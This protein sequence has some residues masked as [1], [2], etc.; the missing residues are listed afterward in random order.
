MILARCGCRWTRRARTAVG[1]GWD[2]P[3]RCAGVTTFNALRH[4]RAVAGDRVAVQFAVLSGVRA[5]IEEM[6]LSKAAEGYAAMEQGRARY[7][8]VLT[9]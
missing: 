5:L 6:P 9:M 4:T 3:W 2:L 1:A 7:R 8:V